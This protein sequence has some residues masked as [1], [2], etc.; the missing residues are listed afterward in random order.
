M[1]KY[2]DMPLAGLLA[3][4]V[5]LIRKLG[6]DEKTYLKLSLQKSV[7][8]GLAGI[9]LSG[10]GLVLLALSG[11][12]LLVTLTLLLNVWLLP[13]VSALIMTGAL[14]L[15]GLILGFTGMRKARKEMRKAQADMNRVKE[16]MTWLK[17][18]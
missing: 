9:I 2:Q 4:F 6:A 11:I 18:N 15:S 17:E 8:T 10:A 1:D 14:L 13:W 7:Q 3:Q 5:S 12:F 16:D